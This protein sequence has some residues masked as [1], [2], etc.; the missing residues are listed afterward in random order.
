MAS[1]NA[2][3]TCGGREGDRG[4]EHVCEIGDVRA[5]GACEA[6]AMPAG[7]VETVVVGPLQENCYL[8][9]D[10]QGGVV[11]VDPGDDWPR[12]QAALA[13]RP[14]DIVLVTHFH[15]DHVGALNG[16]LASTGAGWVIGAP[17]AKMLEPGRARTAHPHYAAVEVATPPL[18]TLVGRDVVEAGELRFEVIDCPGHSKGGVTYYERR[19]GLAFTGDTLFAGSCGRT[20]LEGGSG[21]AILSSLARL[22]KLPEETRVLPGHGPSST[23]GAERVTNPYVRRVLAGA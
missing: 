15:A 18:R 6:D 13:G 7:R 21:R 9:H 8:V 4:A 23:I 16:L 12:I 1:D 17:D 2:G 19:F 10:G 3:V 14:V 20:D 5:H 22:A 11:V